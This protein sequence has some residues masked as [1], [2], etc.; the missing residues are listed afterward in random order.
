MSP[1]PALDP[2]PTPRACLRA[3]GLRATS[4]RQ[5]TLRA[6]R[7]APGPL[8][9]ATL[10]QEVPG[11]D[12]A[13]L[14]RTLNRLVEV[15]LAQVVIELG[16]TRRFVAVRADQPA[17]FATTL[18]HCTE[19]NRR[20]PVPPHGVRV[21]LDLPGWSASLRRAHARVT[22]RGPCPDCLSPGAA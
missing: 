9:A 22:L 4:H 8:R 17:T 12:R 21:A 11:L 5:A 15:G 14:Y 13:T 18:L 6:L 20:I 1:S 2:A 16:G 10:L 19:C 7:A 3:A